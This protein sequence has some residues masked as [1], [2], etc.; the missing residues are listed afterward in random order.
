[1]RSRRRAA[2]AELFSLLQLIQ[3]S[4]T[5]RAVIET[6]PWSRVVGTVQAPAPA[7]PHATLDT[8][9]LQSAAA[10]PHP[11]HKSKLVHPCKH[12]QCA[13]CD[14]QTII[15][16]DLL[17]PWL[18]RRGGM[19]VRPVTRVLVAKE[20][21]RWLLDEPARLPRALLPRKRSCADQ[22]ASVEARR[23]EGNYGPL[24]AKAGGA[25]R[26]RSTLRGVIVA[27]A[28]NGLKNLLARSVGGS[29]SESRQLARAT[30]HGWR[31]PPS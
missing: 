21:R 13:I 7:P 6:W 22:T 8:R 9:P 23:L 18:H 25:R 16:H 20:R 17:P 11:G 31:C 27:E 14:V 19:A 10:Y 12:Y 4:T 3:S 2:S 1:M 29:G 15:V 5:Q 26:S 24:I 30:V 28:G